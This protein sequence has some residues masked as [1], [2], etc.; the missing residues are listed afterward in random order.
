MEIQIK[1]NNDELVLVH[2]GLAVL[3]AALL[4]VVIAGTL[5]A[6][7]K[8]PGEDTSTGEAI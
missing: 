4:A 1:Q 8:V 6:R 7:V 2:L 5:A 3:I